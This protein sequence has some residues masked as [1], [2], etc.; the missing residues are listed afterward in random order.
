M[1]GPP[2]K[3]P[4][5][6]QRRNRVSS[7]KVL[8]TDAPKRRAPPLP[9]N[10]EW[11]DLTKAWWKDVWASP[12]AAEYLESDV[13]GLYMLGE[14]IELFWTKPSTKMASEIRQQGA[15]YGLDPISRRRLQWSVQKVEGSK[16]KRTAAVSSDNPR[17][18]LRLVE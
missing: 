13:H 11:R 5:V 10:R 14:L 15:C 1:K 4:G 2:P 18:A 16:R 7:G 12:M 3:S 8:P 9:Q 17:D 6:R